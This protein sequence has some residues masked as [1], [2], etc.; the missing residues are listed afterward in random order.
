M[1]L[2]APEEAALM[3]GNAGRH[4]PGHGADRIWELLKSEEGGSTVLEIMAHESVVNQTVIF[5]LGRDQLLDILQDV[6]K[7]MPP[8]TGP[9]P[10]PR[11]EDGK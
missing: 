11:P 5:L 2:L 9:G 8:E 7:G 4:R 1:P 3:E 6:G 10:A